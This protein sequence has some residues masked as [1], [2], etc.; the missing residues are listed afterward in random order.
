MV[1]ERP[2]SAVFQSSPVDAL[3]AKWRRQ[4]T[5]AG[6]PGD[7]VLLAKPLTFMNDSG[8]GVGELTRYEIDLADLL[9]VVDDVQLP[10]GRLRLHA[11]LSR[12]P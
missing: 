2:G 1:D 3:V 7:V 9:V 5:L 8:Q 12:R 11:R 6:V 10:A 4:P